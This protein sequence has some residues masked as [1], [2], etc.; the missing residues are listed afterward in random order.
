MN[1]RALLAVICGALAVVVGPHAA[2]VIATLVIL[3][4]VT[5]LGYCVLSVI[6]QTGW[7]TVP[8]RRRLA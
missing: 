2:L 3:G 5:V 7:R 4:T 6:L 8:A 1:P